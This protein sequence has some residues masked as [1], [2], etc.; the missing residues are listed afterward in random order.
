MG[1]QKQNQPWK[2]R[3]ARARAIQLVKQR[4]EIASTPEERRKLLA[5]ARKGQTRNP[6]SIP[7][8]D[9]PNQGERDSHR[10]RPAQH[11][12][13]AP[14]ATQPDELESIGHQDEHQD[15][16]Q[17]I[18]RPGDRNGE[19]WES[20]SLGV[21]NPEKAA[22]F[23]HQ[24]EEVPVL[25]HAAKL[26]GMSKATIHDWRK[27]SPAFDKAVRDALETGIDKLE[28]ETISQALQPASQGNPTHLL[29]MF[30]LKSRRR[31]V[32]GERLEVNQTHRHEI[33]IDLVPATADSGQPATIESRAL[34]PTGTDDE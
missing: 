24:L 14:T 21:P 20:I 5:T 11:Q 6:N 3:E 29:K 16:H 22:L 19:R 34:P 13:A 2:L 10:K 8:E 26:I 9:R 32:Y 30:T 12:I 18:T 15:E 27:R 7:I 23:L 28:A 31:E 1:V 4:Q 17:E 25:G 33:V